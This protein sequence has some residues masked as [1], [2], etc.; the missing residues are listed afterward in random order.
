MSPQ[1]L[2]QVR[3]KVVPVVFGITLEY[4]VLF[5]AFHEL[6][7]FRTEDFCDLARIDTIGE[8]YSSP[9]FLTL[10]LGRSHGQRK[11]TG[12]IINEPRN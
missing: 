1:S 7:V 4:P 9:S 6:R 2:L 8:K 5:D 11:N 10:K 12:Q 3:I